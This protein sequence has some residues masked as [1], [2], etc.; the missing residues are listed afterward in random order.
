MW[1]GQ[2][3]QGEQWK[4][5]CGVKLHHIEPLSIDLRSQYFTLKSL[6]KSLEKTRHWTWLVLPCKRSPWLPCGEQP[7]VFADDLATV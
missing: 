2:S 7:T 5:E 3:K 4:G 1:L 6:A